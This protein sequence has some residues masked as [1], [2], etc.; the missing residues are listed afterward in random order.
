MS[1]RSV[2][3]GGALLRASRVFSIPTPLPKPAQELTS[4]IIFESDTATT[5]HPL[6]QAITTPPTSLARGDWGFK[7]PLPLRS[8]TRTSTPHIRVTAIDTI[9]HITDFASAADHTLTLKK[10]Q[11]MG[12]SLSTPPIKSRHSTSIPEKFLSAPPQGKGVFEND[13]DRTEQVEGELGSEAVRWR[14]KGPWL[15]GMSEGQFNKYISTQI[16]RRKT[17][18]QQ[19]LRKECAAS[20]T[21]EQQKNARDAGETLPVPIAASE[22]TEEQVMQYTKDL[23]QDEKQ[24]NKLICRFLDLPPLPVA[25]A[26]LDLALTTMLGKPFRMKAEDY[27]PSTNPYAEIG[28]PKTHP[29]AGLSYGRTSATIYNHPLFGPQESHPPIEARV[30]Q[31]TKAA[32][33]SYSETLGVGG[34][35]TGLPRGVSGGFKG[36]NNPYQTQIVP[37]LNSVDPDKE[38]GSKVWVQPQRASVDSKGQVNLEVVLAY[39]EAIAVLEGK[40]KDI[41]TRAMHNHLFD[42]KSKPS[43]AF[44]F[45]KPFMSANIRAS[46]K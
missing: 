4:S 20:L 10:W 5:H 24:R 40:T 35:I 17:E 31:P 1:T 32:V 37:G 42:H 30:V 19:F 25:K 18:F 29:S 38:G 39:P 26:H 45:P 12:I 16:R 11:E 28:P 46:R 23:R 9:E 33:G 34:F 15:A 8:T 21:Q 44:N 2:S 3:P 41:P 43:P 6:H 27:S 7:R 14:Y 13:V 36:T 22:I